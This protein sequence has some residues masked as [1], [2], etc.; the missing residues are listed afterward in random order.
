M[1]RQLKTDGLITP[2]TDIDV[3]T[4]ISDDEMRSH[5]RINTAIE[6]LI[7]VPELDKLTTID[8]DVVDNLIH[9]PQEHL[10]MEMS[11]DSLDRKGIKL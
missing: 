8:D 11:A 1:R 7:G 6:D 5:L 10:D 3:L 2:D 4:N 9:V